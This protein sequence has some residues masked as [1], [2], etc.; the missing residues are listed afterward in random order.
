MPLL[1]TT[2][3]LSKA[4]PAQDPTP[5]PALDLAPLQPHVQP[6]KRA[7]IFPLLLFPLEC[8]DR[9]GFH[10]SI[11]EKKRRSLKKKK[12]SPAP[13]LS[14]PLQNIVPQTA[15]QIGA[16]RGQRH[17]HPSSSSHFSLLFQFMDAFISGTEKVFPSG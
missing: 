4:P 15:I 6:P 9:A 16:Q 11:T 17:R 13:F 10:L 7:N 2:M 5:S 14:A 12:K 3:Y 1:S 8:L